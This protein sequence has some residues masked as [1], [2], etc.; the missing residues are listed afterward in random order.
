MFIYFHSSYKENSFIYSIRSKLL[1]YL[2]ILE[3]SFALFFRITKRNMWISVKV[4]LCVGETEAGGT[5][6]QKQRD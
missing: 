4:F 3:H 2:E 6:S 5:H 1:S